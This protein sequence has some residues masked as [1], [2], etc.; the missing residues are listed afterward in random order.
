MLFCTLQIC[1][2][3]TETQTET[4]YIKKSQHTSLKAYKDNLKHYQENQPSQD[5]LVLLYYEL[6]HSKFCLA[7]NNEDLQPMNILHKK[8]GPN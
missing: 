1:A 3:Q 8:T 4:Q 5:T 6:V 2:K 7:L